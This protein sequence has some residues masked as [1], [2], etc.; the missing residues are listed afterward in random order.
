MGGGCLPDAGERG[1]GAR[2][3]ALVSASVEAGVE[4]GVC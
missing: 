2:W 1:G 4:A 3:W